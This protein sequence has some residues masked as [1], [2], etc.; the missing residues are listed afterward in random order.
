[1]RIAILGAGPAGLSAASYL[2]QDASNKRRDCQVEVIDRESHL[3]GLQRSFEFEGAHF[4][5]GTIL[6]FGHHGMLDAF[7]FLADEMVSIKYQPVSISP[8]GGYDRY[9]FSVKGFLRDNGIAVAAMAGIDLLYSKLRFASK[10]TVEAYARY[11]M[12][13]TVFRKSGLKNYI[14]RLHNLPDT[15]LDVEFAKK[16][17]SLVERQ[18][19]RRILATKLPG[20]KKKTIAGPR[21]VRPEKGFPYMY[22]ELI[23]NHLTQHNVQLRLNEH[24]Q[25]VQSQDNGFEVQLE[26][27]IERFDRVISTIPIPSMLRLLGEAPKTDVQTKNLI[28]LFYKGNFA[29]KGNTFFNFTLDSEW[30]RITVFSRFYQLLSSGEDYFTV[31]VTTDDDTSDARIQSVAKDFEQHAAKHNLLEGPAKLLGSHVSLDA[32]P[33]Y[34]HGQ[35]DAIESE[36]QRLQSTG[37]DLLGR[38]GNFEYVISNIVARRAKELAEGYVPE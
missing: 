12:G 37:I 13:G 34:R 30:K 4:D 3:G 27:G 1:M 32:Y 20:N 8:S 10:S 17:L 29:Q 14:Y 15:E 19:F 33:V 24:I 9:P 6:F 18:S 38:Q 23:R 28:S 2:A 21:L 35:M 16:R 36:K 31:E 7:P 11:Y 5:V 22:E 26:S 25:H